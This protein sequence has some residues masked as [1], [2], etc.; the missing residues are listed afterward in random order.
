MERHG[1]RWIDRRT[2]EYSGAS[3]SVSVLLTLA[4]FASSFLAMRTVTNSAPATHDEHSPPVVI[5]L[6]PPTIR[7]PRREA[8]SR[9]AATVAPNIAVNT[10]SVSPLPAIPSIATPA[11]R[12]TGTPRD[13][14][15]RRGAQAP[16]SVP[17]G[18]AP[19]PSGLADTA[20]GVRGGAPMAPSG[21]T[22]G[23]RN[24]N[25]AR[26][27]DSMVNL[28]IKTGVS[29]WMDHLPTGRELQE[30]QS[31]RSAARALATRTTTSGN[32]RGVNVM[33]GEGMNGEG[34]VG[35]AAGG[36]GTV[37]APIFSSGPSAAQRK[38]D[39][40]LDAEYQLRLRRLQ[41]RLIARR[42]SLRA[43]SLRRDS[44]ARPR[45]P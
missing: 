2:P 12:E 43:D 16:T 38:R 23:S 7:P 42:D 26:F 22:I 4:L 17:L 31:S 44:L 36:P 10:P 33:Q 3:F 27:R 20:M 30:I 21:V 14:T 45:K 28:R 25:T 9:P 34:A 13:T 18:I 24:A 8:A 6:A 39:A 11:E 29:T 41:D 35:G 19:L 1:P 32:G 5:R 37:P 15:S 40:R